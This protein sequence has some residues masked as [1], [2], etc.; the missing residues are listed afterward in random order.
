[1]DEAEQIMEVGVSPAAG[2]KGGGEVIVSSTGAI[3][4]KGAR[5]CKSQH[6][7]PAGSALPHLHEAL[8]TGGC[9]SC[10]SLAGLSYEGRY[11]TQF[12]KEEHNPLS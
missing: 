12:V 8:Y 3:A 11:S 6:A 10:I 1:M 5:C 7:A 4:T 2:A 9:R